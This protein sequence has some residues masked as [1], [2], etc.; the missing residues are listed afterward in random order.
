MTFLLCLWILRKFYFFYLGRFSFLLHLKSSFR[1]LDVQIFVFPSSLLFFPVSHCF[2]DWSKINLKVYD[3]INCINKNL[4]T[5]F[6]CYLEKE[7]SYDI[8]ILPIGRV[9]N[10]EHFYGR[11]MRKSAS[12]TSPIALLILVNSP[13]QP[14]HARNYFKI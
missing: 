5:H 14:L 8:E 1:S 12:E 11:I 13:K 6:V 7:K 3:V 10:N 2:G 4:I 9:L